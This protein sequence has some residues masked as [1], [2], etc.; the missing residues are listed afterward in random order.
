MTYLMM[1]PKN[2]ATSPS[3]SV[4]LREAAFPRHLLRLGDTNQAIK[5]TVVEIL[6]PALPPHRLE[7]EMRD[8]VATAAA[9]KDRQ[10]THGALGDAL[11]EYAI[12]PRARQA[13]RDPIGPRLGYLVRRRLPSE[14]IGCG[15]ACGTSSSSETS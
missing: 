11:G 10:P 4:L 5:G 12:W 8:L 1:R 6:R 9:S 15:R 13:A 3:S 14:R 7:M 2:W